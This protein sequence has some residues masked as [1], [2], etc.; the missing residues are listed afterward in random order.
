[1]ALQMK[2]ACKRCNAS[3]AQD[4]PAFIC[5]NECSFC[6]ACA[7]EMHKI[8]PTCGGELVSRPRRKRDDN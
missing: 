2:S 5:S 3:L 1:M 6:S 7:E 4:G 8:C